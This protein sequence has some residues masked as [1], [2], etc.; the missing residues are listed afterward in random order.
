MTQW[1]ARSTEMTA[2]KKST[3]MAEKGIELRQV[4]MQQS[5]RQDALSHK[6]L[7]D[8]CFFLLISREKAYQQGSG[9]RDVT[10]SSPSQHGR[11][12]EKLTKTESE[13][14]KD[15]YSLRT[16][17]QR[18]AQVV[19]WDQAARDESKD[20]KNS[21]FC[22]VARRDRRKMTQSEESLDTTDRTQRRLTHEMSRK[23]F[24]GYN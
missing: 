10:V 14:K 19:Q 23:V 11:K 22:T 20:I 24:T 7:E 18:V 3:K 6:L 17:E 9:M 15:A 12:W 13:G 1:Q 5:T 2:I 4:T 8:V 16:D 21:R